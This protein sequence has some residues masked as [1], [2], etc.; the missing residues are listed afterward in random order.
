[1]RWDADQQV[2]L[3][4]RHLELLFNLLD[5]CCRLRSLQVRPLLSTLIAKFSY[6]CTIEREIGKNSRT[7]ASY[8]VI[9]FD[10]TK[11]INQLR[12]K[13]VGRSTIM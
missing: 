3:I 7:A 6:A 11:E 4:H 13:K 1:M 10:H 12:A 9:R 5:L 8:A 2:V